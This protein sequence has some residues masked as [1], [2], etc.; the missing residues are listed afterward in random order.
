MKITSF[1]I[2]FVF[3]VSAFTLNAGKIQDAPS[4]ADIQSKRGKT[5]SAYASAGVKKA[6][7]EVPIER[8]KP[9][10]IG[11]SH[12]LVGA[13]GFAIVPRG[14]VFASGRTVKLVETAPQSGKFLA[15]GE[16]YKR[17]RA[18]IRLINITGDQWSGKTSLEP[19]KAQLNAAAA[20]G[21]AALTSL[22][23]E[24]V[25]LPGIKILIESES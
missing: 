14:A 23:G 12:F 18:G 5:D 4:A 13:H 20:S 8:V 19:L 6:E 10:L 2:S 21:Q 16:F 17:H 3:L 7:N 25:S 9:T 15:W 1:T 11:E 22:N 24:P